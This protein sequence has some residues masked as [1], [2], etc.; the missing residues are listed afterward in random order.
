MES[1]FRVRSALLQ[2]YA[3]RLKRE[4]YA[5]REIED[6]LAA[7]IRFADGE[8][9]YALSRQRERMRQLTAFF[10]EMTAAAQQ[11]DEDATYASDSLSA[12]AD[13]MLYQDSR[14]SLFAED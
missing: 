10:G 4:Q 13:E 2:D 1:W 11:L 9:R 8:E 7:C 3:D 14:R 5:A 12:L 6:L